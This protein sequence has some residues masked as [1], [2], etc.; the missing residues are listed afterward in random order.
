MARIT[1]TCFFVLVK[2]SIPVFSLS[3]IEDKGLFSNNSYR[4]CDPF[5]DFQDQPGRRAYDPRQNCRCHYIH[6]NRK[7]VYYLLL[8][9]LLGLVVQNISKSVPCIEVTSQAGIYI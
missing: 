9:R 6:I 1:I 4:Y 8:F 3:C 2:L 5:G 7:G